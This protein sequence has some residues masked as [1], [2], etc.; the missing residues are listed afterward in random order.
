MTQLFIGYK[1]NVG[2]VVKVLR[3]DADDALTL[4]NSAYDRYYF[5]SENQKLAIVRDQNLTYVNWWNDPPSVSGNIKLF[6]GDQNTARYVGFFTK[7]YSSSNSGTCNIYARRQNIFRD[8]PFPPMAEVRVPPSDGWITSGSRGLQWV[9]DGTGT[10]PR[11]VGVYCSYQYAATW[12]KPRYWNTNIDWRNRFSSALSFMGEDEWVLHPGNGVDGRDGN[13]PYNI[14]YG[15]NELSRDKM[16]IH[17]YWDFPADGAP[18]V[19]YNNRPDLEI[20]RSNQQGVIMSRP[21]YSVDSSTGTRHRILDSTINLASVVM[22][23]TQYGIQP[24]Q[25]VDIP[26]NLNMPM[27]STS[28]VEMMVKESGEEQYVPPHILSGYAKDRSLF[29]QHKVNPY[30]ISIRNRG[31]HSIDVTYVVFN[32][33]AEPQTT[34]GSEI[35]RKVNINGREEVQIKK[36]N[37]SDTNPKVS[38]LLLDTRFP[39]MQII[40]EGFIPAH[41]FT[42]DPE[43]PYLLGRVAKQINFNNNG[44]KPFVKFNLVFED[45]IHPPI[46]S[47]AYN[48]QTS[49]GANGGSKFSSLARVRDNNVKFWMNPDSWAS[50]R[51]YDG[52]VIVEW[53]GSNPLGIRYYIFGVSA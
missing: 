13:S 19:S 26:S 21:G 33:D 25:T 50:I 45:R 6:G 8:V 40:Q 12:V 38:D 37:S 16:I 17:A 28:I 15:E 9:F 3:Y 22:I 23:G 35:I 30:S 2:P 18:M 53:F 52:R 31:T 4:A 29:V 46:M 27:A 47:R 20:Y 34:G 32:I 49:T 5:N 42:D 41:A 51:L 7:L 1:P 36:P 43:N 10:D 14:S 24:G 48:Y 44:F 39:T 11:E